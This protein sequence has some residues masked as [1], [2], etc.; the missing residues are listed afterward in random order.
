M[1]LFKENLID[2]LT[3]ECLLCDFHVMRDAVL[4]IL[5]AKVLDVFEDDEIALIIDSTE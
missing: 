3:L 2:I 4:V 1:L 5:I